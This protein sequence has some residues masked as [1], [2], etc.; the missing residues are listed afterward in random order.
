LAI[1]ALGV[2]TTVRIPVASAAPAGTVA[3]IV[4]PAS[5]AVFRSPRAAHGLLVV[6]GG[7]TVSRRGSQAN[8]VRGEVGNSILPGGVPGGEP[9]IP[10]SEQPAGVTFYVALPP[11]GEHHNVRRYPIA[12]VGP[13]YR[14]ILSDSS[15]HIPGLISIADVARSALAID[16]GKTPPIRSHPSSDPLGELARFDRRLSKAHDARLG[17]PIVLVCPLLS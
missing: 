3:V 17:A 14:G 16:Q 15:T 10:L 12:V 4:K 6:G 2:M 7:A 13:G 9:L 8:L 5:A 1:V 11:P